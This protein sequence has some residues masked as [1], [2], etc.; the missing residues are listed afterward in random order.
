MCGAD[1]FQP[2]SLPDA[3]GAGIEN[4]FG[5]GFPV[6]FAAGHFQI[7]GNVP[8]TEGQFVF[9]RL[10]KAGNFRGKTAVSAGV[11]AGEFA[12]YP[13]RTG[14]IHRAEMQVN[15]LAV[16]GFWQG[17]RLAVPYCVVNFAGVDTGKFALVGIGNGYFLVKAVGVEREVPFAVEVVPIFAHKLRTGVF[18]TRNFHKKSAFLLFAVFPIIT[19]GGG[20]VIGKSS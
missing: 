3:G 4:P 5:G 13:N 10:Q 19:N 6:L 7:C 11:F 9:A 8:H 12:V 2:D 17:E 16:H 20:V 18:R 15:F 1:G 14:I